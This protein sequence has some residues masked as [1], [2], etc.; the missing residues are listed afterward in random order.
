MIKDETNNYVVYKGEVNRNIAVEEL[1]VFLGVLI[2]AGYNI[3][4]SE[5]HFW[6][7]SKDLHNILIN[8]FETYRTFD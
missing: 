8:R 2:I 1:K 3:T 5:K 6:S 4:P 7:N